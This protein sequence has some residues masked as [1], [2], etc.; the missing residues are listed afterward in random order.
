[1]SVTYFPLILFKKSRVYTKFK[2]SFLSLSRPV[3]PEE[4]SAVVQQS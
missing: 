3:D 1:M 2:L 4:I